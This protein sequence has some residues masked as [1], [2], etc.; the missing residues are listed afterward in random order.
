MII[1]ALDHVVTFVKR[2]V[3]LYLM[4]Y[5]HNLLTF[6][7]Y[8][9]YTNCYYISKQVTRCLTTLRLSSSSKQHMCME[10]TNFKSRMKSAWARESNAL[11][12]VSMMTAATALPITHRARCAGCSLCRQHVF[13]TNMNKKMDGNT[14]C[15]KRYIKKN[16]HICLWMVRPKHVSVYSKSL[17][18]C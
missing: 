11:P 1:P 6:L 7:P 3:S 17:K 2:W 18:F 13:P 8:V 5:H 15:Y 12:C 4:V 10:I 16:L 9:I 14:I